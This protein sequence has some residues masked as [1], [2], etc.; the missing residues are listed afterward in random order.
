MAEPAVAVVT[1]T[2][3]RMAELERCLRSVA[4]QDYAGP[5]RHVVVGDHLDAETAEA[6][7]ALCRRFLARFHNDLRPLDTAYPPARAGRVRNLGTRLDDAPWVAHLDE[8][9]AFDPD[10]LSSLAAL[11][12]RPDVDIAYGWRR[13]LKTDGEPLRLRR[14]PWVIAHREAVAK[15]VFDL[16]VAEGMFEVGGCV[17]RDRVPDA[18]GDLFHVDSSEW[19]MKRHVFDAVSFLERATPREM[20]YQYSEDYLFCRDAA[21]HGFRFACSERVTLS[22]YLGGYG[23][24]DQPNLLES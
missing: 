3:G 23:C 1:P 4:G 10:H 6:A 15:E 13:M 14:Y 22:Y 20:I 16:L 21:R 11:L 19:M 8:D 12:A 2:V 17:I 9:N 5:V 18:H 24:G 7:C